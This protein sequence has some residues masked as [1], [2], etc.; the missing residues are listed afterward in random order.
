MVLAPAGP[1]AAAPG[2]TYRRGRMR[3][4]RRDAR[5][6]LLRILPRGSVGAEIGVW[7]G[8]FSARILRT[9]RPAKLHLI[10]P[11]TFMSDEAYRDAWY[12]G[13]LAADQEA[14]DTIHDGVVLRF[15]REIAA[16]VVEVHRSTSAEASSRF[17]DACFDWVYVDGNHLYEAVRADLELFDPKLKSDGLLAGDDYGL[18]GW[19]DD[20]VTRAVDDIVAAGGYEVVAL[21]SNQFVL[22]KLGRP[23]R[24]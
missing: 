14:M 23:S 13:K 16:G 10:D 17:P 4:R 18:P 7:R 19:W 8:D 1:L 20:G 2:G 11:W 3:I 6:F 12:G 5:R 21:A 22:R 15:A 9:V 24:P